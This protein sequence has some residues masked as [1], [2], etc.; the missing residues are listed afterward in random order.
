MNEAKPERASISEIYAQGEEN[1]KK[2]G[3]EWKYP[4]G[5]KGP[6]VLANRRYLDCLFFEPKFFEPVEVDTT[7]TLFGTK[8][9]APVF[10]SA[11]SRR[12]FMSEES[13]AE[14]AKGVFD[15]GSLIILGIGGSSELQKAIDTGAPV[16][17]MVKPYRNMEQVYKK[18]RD[19]ENR[20][21][22][23]VGMDIDHAYGLLLDGKVSKTKL[24]GPQSTAELKEVISECKLPFVFKGIL[25][26][27]DAKAAAQLGASAVI[28]SNHGSGAF[29]FTVPSMIALP[30]IVE[31]VGK[32]L[33][34]LVDTGFET[35]NDVFKALGFGA[36]AVG[37]ASPVVLAYAARSSEGVE[38][39]INEITADL[40]RTMAA[41]G[42]S[43]LAHIAGTTIIQVPS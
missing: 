30:K 29:D 12:P 40:R 1:L 13:L 3:V 39:L 26:V 24:F 23:A 8:L 20:G 31:T 19:A 32:T 16:V 33:T 36:K 14:I 27:S 21:C 25:S 4:G 18:V 37:F 9:K 17:K 22:V 28:V 35:G 34:V 6:A 43:N 7:C 10:C 38:L 42:C 2:M 41:T 11:I 5:K 15:A